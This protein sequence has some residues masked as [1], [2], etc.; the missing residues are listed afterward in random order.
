MTRLVL[1]ALAIVAITL[2][3]AYGASYEPPNDIDSP[4]RTPS[5]GQQVV[6]VDG[7][8]VGAQGALLTRGSTAPVEVASRLDD[9]PLGLGRAGQRGSEEGGPPTPSAAAILAVAEGACTGSG[10]TWVPV[11]DHH[12]CW[13]V[14]GLGTKRVP[15]RARR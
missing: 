6:G 14:P 11:G 10:R 13:P 3:G 5:P 2:G 15:R 4:S 9:A 1:A 8:E 7:S 12:E